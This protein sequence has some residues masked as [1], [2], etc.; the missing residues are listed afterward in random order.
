[1]EPNDSPEPTDANP[2]LVDGDDGAITSTDPK[3]RVLLVLGVA[4]VAIVGLIAIFASNTDTETG[5][6]AAATR[7]AMGFTNTDGT[8]G[9][10]ADYEGSPT[11]VNFFASWCAPCR[12]ELPDFEAVH[13]ASGDQ[14]QFLGVNHDI[15]ESSWKGF[16][17]E[18]DVTYPTVFQPGQEL[19]KDLGL[20]GMPST[21]FVTADGEIVHT[22]SGLLTKEAL[23]DL[24]VEHLGVEV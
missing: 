9:S 1:M 5:N 3:L 16:V 7:S 21:A 17:A 13:V 18:T 8:T 19:W 10:L 20:F 12:A 2:E 14:V 15:D 4:A 11:V 24:I 6:A 23:E 22:H